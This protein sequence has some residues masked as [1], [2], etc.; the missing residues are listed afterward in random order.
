VGVPRGNG[1]RSHDRWYA[2]EAV[3]Y[4]KDNPLPE[5]AAAEEFTLHRMSVHFGV[6][7]GYLKGIVAELQMQP[8]NDVTPAMALSG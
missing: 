5:L 8:I 3:L 6:S 1:D 7:E 4:L 2:P